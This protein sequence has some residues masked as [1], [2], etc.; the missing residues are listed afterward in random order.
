MNSN[1]HNATS[2]TIAITSRTTTTETTANT[3][4]TTTIRFRFLGTWYRMN[5]IT[6]RVSW[7]LISTFEMQQ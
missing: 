5:K 1:E 4:V 6:L 3:T 7:G 2:A